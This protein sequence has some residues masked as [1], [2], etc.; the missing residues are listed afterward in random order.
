[1]KDNTNKTAICG[2]L[3]SAITIAIALPK[4]SLIIDLVLFVGLLVAF[5]YMLVLRRNN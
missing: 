3:I 5:I 4:S 2:L 1:M